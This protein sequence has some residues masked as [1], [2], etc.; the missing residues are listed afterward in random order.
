MM[1][2]A[3]LVRAAPTEVNSAAKQY[4]GLLENFAG[5]AEQHWNE[6]EQSYDAKGSGVTW[7]R[8]NGGMCLVNAVLLT[9]FPDKPTFSPRKVPRTVML[10]HIRRTLRSLCLNSKSC[11]DARATKPG[12]WGG[13]DDGGG[14]HWQAGLETEHWALAA[15]LLASQLDE[16]TKR[17]VRQVATAEADLAVKK[18]PSAKRGNTAADDCVWNAGV[19]GVCAAIYVEDPRAAK[20]DEWAKRWALNAESREVDR[21]S[22]RRIDGKPL[23]EWLVSTNVFADLTMENHNF[24]DLPY[25]TSF[26]ALVEPILAYHLCGWKTPEAFHANALEEGN[27][28]LR[29][30]VMPD[31]DLLCPQG[32]DWAER[33]VQHSWAFTEL[34]TFLDQPWARAAEARCLKLLT[35]RQS[36]FGDGSIRALDFGYETDLAVMWA[37][38]FLLHKHFSKA[39]SGLAFDEPRGAKIFPFVAAA[40]YRTPDLVSS[41]T[42]FRSRQAVLVSPNNLDMLADRPTFTRYDAESGTGWILLQGDKRHRTLRMTGEPHIAQSGGALAVSF[43]REVPGFVRQDIGYCALPSSEVAVFSRWQALREIEVAELVDHPF[44]WVEID[45]FISKPAAKQIAS[46]GWI[47]DG[48]LQIRIFDAASGELANDGLNGSA[49]RGFSAKANEVLQDSVCVYQPLAIGRAVSDAKR[50][51]HTVCIG[52]WRI[53]QEGDGR[54][55]AKK[56][57]EP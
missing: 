12:T 21:Q 45:T 35:K 19:L 38:S 42:W 41:V 10:D 46:N 54:L 1:M 22:Q 7:A 39:D 17:L 40:V 32:I 13:A 23:G 36:V 4:L 43:R 20:W 48:K 24:W 47:I 33:D 27:E 31:G 18:I 55:S 26:A 57:D 25:Q 2:Q 14:G 56:A 52:A 44:R 50:E 16:D 3:G 28:I 49:R 9:E 5:F 37:F 15:H 34:G 30:L 51:A 11:T 29:W 8:G 53:Q 6:K